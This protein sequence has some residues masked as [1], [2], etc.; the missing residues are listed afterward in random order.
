MNKKD[1]LKELS[2]PFPEE[3]I[4]WRIG[5]SG[6][7]ND[8]SRWATALAYIDSRAVMDRLDEVMG[9]DGWEDS[10][11]Q[12][13]GGFICGIKLK[14]E[15]WEVTKWD[16]A[17]PTQFE[18]FKGMLSGAFKR[19]V[20]KIGIGRYLYNLPETFVECSTEKRNDWNYQKDKNGIFYWKTPKISPEF[21]PGRNINAGDKNE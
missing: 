20:V 6:V 19:A 11:K 10:L 4:L 5:R 17:E 13:D 3:D 16:G 7:K 18:G 14:G 12:C 9:I 1:I 2:K 15:D 8:R 21:L